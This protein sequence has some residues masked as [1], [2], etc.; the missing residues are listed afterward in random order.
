MKKKDHFDWKLFH[1]ILDDIVIE[2]KDNMPWPLIK[3]RGAEA[4]DIIAVLART[5]IQREPI[6]IVSADKDL[7][8]LQMKSKKIK[9]YSP[10]VRKQ[11]TLEDYN[12]TEH[13]IRGDSSD[14]IPCI[15]ADDDVFLVDTKRQPSIYQKFVE[16]IIEDISNIPD[17][18]ALN[19]YNR[20]KK[21]ID[22]DCIP[23]KLNDMILDN[24]DKAIDNTHD[25]VYTYL[26]K[27]RM[28]KFLNRMNEFK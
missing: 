14:G 2:L 9:Q 7:K 5:Y 19:K 1:K 3:I 25:K 26:V 16:S 8:Q 17:E 21:L 22:V 10:K 4:D 11:L 28:R 18:T 27:H 20:N 12:L 23:K 24:Y 6:M 15:L 13:I